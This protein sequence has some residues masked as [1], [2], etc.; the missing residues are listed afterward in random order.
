MSRSP[1]S[2]GR[3]KHMNR[4][5]TLAWQWCHKGL[6]FQNDDFYATWDGVFS[7][8]SSIRKIWVITISLILLWQRNIETC[9]RMVDDVDLCMRLILGIVARAPWGPKSNTSTPSWFP[10]KMLKLITPF[11]RP[12]SADL[13]QEVQRFCLLFMY[14]AFVCYSRRPCKR[15]LTSESILNKQ[16]QEENN[17]LTCTSQRQKKT[18]SSVLVQNITKL[19]LTSSFGRQ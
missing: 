17:T 14:S 4:L 9:D 1:C 16:I 13:R 6:H 19:R 8:I 15:Q 3:T 10:H 7:A 11:V 12:V 5:R 2:Q 18:K